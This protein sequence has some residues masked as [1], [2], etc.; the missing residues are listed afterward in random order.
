MLKMPFVRAIA[1]RLISRAA[2]AADRYYPTAL[3]A[4]LIT[5]CI[6]NLEVA[7]NLY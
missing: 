3:E 1:K 7:V 4:I 2:A 6:Y 5:L